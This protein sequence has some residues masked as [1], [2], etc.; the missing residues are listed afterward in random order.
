MIKKDLAGITSL[1]SHAASKLG[2]SILST[3]M[4]NAITHRTTR[5]TVSVLWDQNSA[6]KGLSFE[7]PWLAAA[8]YSGSILLLDIE[9]ALKGGRGGDVSSSSS[10]AAT[11][12]LCNTSRATRQRFTG[13]RGPALCVDMADCYLACGSGA[14]LSSEKTAPKRF[15]QSLPSGIFLYKLMC[16]VHPGLDESVVVDREDK[17]H[18]PKDYMAVDFGKSECRPSCEVK[19]RDRRHLD[20]LMSMHMLSHEPRIRHLMCRGS[21]GADVGL[22][23]QRD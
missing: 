23:T 15:L 19:C 20:P 18:K 2:L 6:V 11:K 3:M 14:D 12:K 7:D 5:Q 21:S 13:P 4:S 10:S 9:S 16:I 1:C 22:P 17:R 8:T